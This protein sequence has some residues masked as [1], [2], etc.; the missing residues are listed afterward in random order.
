MTKNDYARAVLLGI[1]IGMAFLSFFYVLTQE[2]TP[3]IQSNTP[4][5]NFTV[6]E[7]YKGCDVV[8]YTAP[9]EARYHYFL[10][11]TN[12]LL[13]GMPYGGTSIKARKEKYD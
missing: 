8:R 12:E 13:M 9:T 1:V 7:S 5:F 3:E 10:D 2:D 6:V 4:M 11:C